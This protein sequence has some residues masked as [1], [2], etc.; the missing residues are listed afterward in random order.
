M[1]NNKPRFPQRSTI[2]KAV[3]YFHMVEGKD[4]GRLF[5]YLREELGNLVGD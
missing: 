1:I 3:E 2:K 4:C 5:A